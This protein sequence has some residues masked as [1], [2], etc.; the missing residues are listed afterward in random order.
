MVWRAS[1]WADFVLAIDCRSLRRAN[2]AGQNKWAGFAAQP[3]SGGRIGRRDERRQPPSA[4][5]QRKASG[6]PGA[7]MSLTAIAQLT[8]IMRGRTSVAPAL[9]AER[10]PRRAPRKAPAPIA[11]PA[12]T[13][14]CPARA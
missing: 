11:S 1:F 2:G 3:C 12:G 9:I 13:T 5:I 10:A 7:A 14:I 4:H 8:V 6:P